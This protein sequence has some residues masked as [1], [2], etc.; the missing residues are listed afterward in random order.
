MKIV[1]VISLLFLIISLVGL[2]FAQEKRIAKIIDFNGKVKIKPSAEEK[3]IPLEVGRELGEGDALKVGANS[4][5]LLNLDGNGEIATVEVTEN[6]QVLISQLIRDNE[7]GKEVTLLDLAIGKL[8]IEVKK[9]ESKESK[10]EVKTP[11]SIVDI[12][13]AKFTVEVEAL[14]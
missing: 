14:E 7:T 6:S 4:L 5:V 8:L 10:F 13:G 1:A 12:R 9:L 3:W 11:T 2:G